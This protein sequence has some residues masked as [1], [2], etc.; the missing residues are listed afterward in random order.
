MRRCRLSL[1]IIFTSGATDS[2]NL[3][4]ESWGSRNLGPGDEVLITAPRQTARLGWLRN[5]W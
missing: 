3:V 5:Y 4:A 1:R 2:I